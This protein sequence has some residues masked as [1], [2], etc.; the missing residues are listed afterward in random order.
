MISISLT[1]IA[2]GF[3][4]TLL[5]CLSLLVVHAQVSPPGVN[6]SR[7]PKRPELWTTVTSLLKQGKRDE[8][9]AL[10]EKEKEK[11]PLSQDCEKILS[12]L[13]FGQI[14]SPYGEDKSDYIVKR[15]DTLTN[16]ARK[17][18]CSIDYIIAINNISDSGKLSVGDRFRVR[19]LNMKLRIDVK[20]KS[21]A[22]I[23]KDKVVK[24]YPV[25]ALR[26]EGTGTTKTKVK[27][28][29]GVYNGGAIAAVSEYFPSADKIIHL[30]NRMVINSTKDSTAPAPGF[31]LSVEDCNELALL[32]VAGNEVEIVH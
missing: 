23:D 32:L 4:K 3:C 29:T 11:E 9:Q 24:V 7:W 12:E 1:S 6:Y 10:L 18:K 28:K 31:Y 26:A 30:N 14:L 25:L 27:N 2:R 13:K 15:G 21:I 22:V 17:T 8:A 20:D 16:I 5:A 19:E